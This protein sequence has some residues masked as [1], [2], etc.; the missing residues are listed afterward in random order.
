MIVSIF[1]GDIVPEDCS[2]AAADVI[3]AIANA[4]AQSHFKL[5]IV[6]LLSFQSENVRA[7]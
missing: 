5:F 2:W 4:A 6:N 1:G 7:R 3:A